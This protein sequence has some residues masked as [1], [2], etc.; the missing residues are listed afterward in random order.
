MQTN[1]GPTVMEILKD[2]GIIK[3][4][5]VGATVALGALASKIKAPSKEFFNSFAFHGILQTVIEFTHAIPG[6]E[7]FG[8]DTEIAVKSFST[9]LPL[10]NLQQALRAFVGEQPDFAKGID[11]IKSAL[12]NSIAYLAAHGCRYVGRAV[13]NSATIK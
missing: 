11:H 7:R 5:V 1:Q 4:A 6:A 2:P 10:Y 3:T 13:Y 12:R 8:S 9:I